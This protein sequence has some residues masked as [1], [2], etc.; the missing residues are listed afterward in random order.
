MYLVVRMVE[1]VDV[2]VDGA[3]DAA[4]FSAREKPVAAVLAAATKYTNTGSNHTNN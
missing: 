1:E 3:V 4:V 2:M